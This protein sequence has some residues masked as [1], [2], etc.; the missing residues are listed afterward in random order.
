[1]EDGRWTDSQRSST[2][3]FLSSLVHFRI[4]PATDVQPS[5]ATAAAIS[6]ARSSLATLLSSHILHDGELVLLILRP[7]PWFI[8]L[9]SLRFIA[10]VLIVA[11]AGS[12][13][14]PG[15]SD[16]V[17][18]DIAAVAIA[19]RLMFAVLA[20][21]GRLYVLTDLRIVRISGVFT[22]N[23]FDCPLRKIARTRL[24]FPI[25]ERLLGVGSIEITPADECGRPTMWAAVS[26][27]VEVHE[28]VVAAINRA[29]Q[30]GL[31]SR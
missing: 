24:W 20:W 12:M 18:V 5:E 23:V 17:Y 31:G 13:W 29:K 19:A 4:S 10:A 7:S 9:S 14:G 16:R 22:V 1:M 28:T 2:S 21:M 11:I 3:H 25:R 27:P 15:F 30:N 26:R 6:G 8:L